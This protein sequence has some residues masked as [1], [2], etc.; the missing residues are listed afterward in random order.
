MSPDV[1]RGL[2]P[3]IYAD[4]WIPVLGSYLYP[5]RYFGSD[6]S[7]NPLDYLEV[8]KVVRV[9]E[10]DV[11]ITRG[12]GL[13]VRMTPNGRSEEEVERVRKILNLVV[14]ELAFAGIK[15]APINDTD[16]QTGKLIGRHIS[17]VGGFGEYGQRTWG[18][19][20]LLSATPTAIGQAATYWPPNFYWLVADPVP[21]DALDE[22]PNARI[23]RQVGEQVPEIFCAA[24][25][26]G[27]QH[28]LGE[29]I[30]SAWLVCEA[31][32]TSRWRTYL[33]QLD[34]SRRHR[35][36]DFR[37]YSAS[38]QLETLLT[39]GQIDTRTYE[40]L[41]A[42]RKVRND[43]A[44][45]VK[46]TQRGADISLTAMRVALEMVNANVERIEGFAFMGGSIGNPSRIP[47]PEFPFD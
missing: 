27:A 17:I 28:S 9:D 7:G 30:L 15:S 14:C 26:H 1:I 11:A 35:L 25:S 32:L 37:I 40:A 44:H 38:V 24:V 12:G 34:S 21:I 19:F 23:L 39:A 22:L 46:M 2:E 5:L 4:A 33:R 42:A 18:P 43:L 41:H 16:I 36:E 8:I 6:R 20:S 29:T 10:T 13:F 45:N 3:F 47:E 31:I